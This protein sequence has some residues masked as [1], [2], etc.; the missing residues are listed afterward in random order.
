MHPTFV[1]VP[2]SNT[3]GRCFSAL[4]RELALLGHRSLGVD[5]PGRGTA[6]FSMAYHTQDLAAFAEEASPMAAVTHADVTA[7]VIDLV[8]RAREHGPVVLVG[9]SRGGL[10]LTSVANAV[11]EL[12][13]RLVYVSAWCCVDSTV[14]GYSAEPALQSTALAEA[15]AV[16]VADPQR[17]GALRMN[18][19]T[20]DPAHLA[21]LRR[22]MVHESTTDA[23]LL[24]FLA[25]MDPDESLDG[26]TDRADAG[27]WGT[28]P[29]TYV[30]FPEDTSMPIALQ[31]RFI[32]EADALT[33]ANPFDVH[34]LP[35]GHID[36]LLHPRP[37]AEILARTVTPR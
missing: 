32:E 10:A 18:W 8:R 11:P 29:R 21:A 25:I 36:P 37:L 22:A 2:G 20:G 9:H 3:G 27:T 28:V 33:P 4:Q 30:R 6:G 26:G 31:D 5:L 12:V 16:L 15:A 7:H 23:E 34:S 1:L 24:A 19:R 17:L 35:G 14:A 13:Q